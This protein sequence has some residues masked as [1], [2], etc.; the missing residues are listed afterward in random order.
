MEETK[1]KEDYNL[2][3]DILYCTLRRTH[4]N[5]IKEMYPEFGLPKPPREINI[6]C[7]EEDNSFINITD[8]MRKNS[9]QV[10][11]LWQHKR[12]DMLNFNISI[13]CDG[14]KEAVNARKGSNTSYYSNG[15]R[16]II[17]FSIGWVN[18]MHKVQSNCIHESSHY[19]H[20]LSS[21]I[22]LEK[23]LSISDILSAQQ[24]RF[25]EFVAE[26]GLLTYSYKKDQLRLIL[27]NEFREGGYLMEMFLA[28]YGSFKSDPTLLKNITNMNLNDGM[29]LVDE[30]IRKYH[31]DS[32]FIENEQR[33]EQIEQEDTTYN[34]E[35]DNDHPF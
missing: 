4:R 24:K 16:R 14:F 19:L 8:C 25:E 15:K 26:L 34:D 20:W 35:P 18:Y 6:T 1:A 23:R 29:A 33:R 22:I 32:H 7:K 28:V 2:E 17:S 31:P 5:F 9:N 10:S 30:Y 13:G 3:L 11:Y 21:P 12:L 27:E